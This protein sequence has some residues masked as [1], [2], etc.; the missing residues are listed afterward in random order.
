MVYF[1]HGI[2]TSSKIIPTYQSTS[3]YLPGTISCA[4]AGVGAEGP[5]FLSARDLDWAA[6]D[7]LLITLGI[8]NKT[9]R[10]LLKYF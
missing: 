7:M 2:V 10:N 5:P 3:V 8:Y 9:Q 6:L 4:I 1:S